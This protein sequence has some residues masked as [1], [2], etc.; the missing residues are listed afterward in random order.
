MY[1]F[2][3]L[4]ASGDLAPLAHLALM[5]TG[6]GDAMPADGA[7]LPA[8]T[9]LQ[10]HGI[11]PIG[12]KSKEGLAL[13]NGTQFSCAYAAWAVNRA[14]E[15]MDLANICAALSLDGYNGNLSPLIPGF[16]TSGT[17]GA[18]A[19]CRRHL[20]VAGGQRNCDAGRQAA[21]GSLCISLRASGAWSIQGRYHAL[22]TDRR[23]R[24]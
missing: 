13:V 15:L 21:S 4:G 24:D 12:L 11:A 2:G 8:A 18:G 1:Q 10:Q 22:R 23:N 3:S 20:S 5:L 19:Y 16:N 9:F 14:Y 17:S 7:V 6:E